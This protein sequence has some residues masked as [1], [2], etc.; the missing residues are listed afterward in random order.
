MLVRMQVSGHVTAVSTLLRTEGL[1]ES[2]PC[3][4]G[5]RLLIVD[6]VI[7]KVVTIKWF[8]V[9]VLFPIWVFFP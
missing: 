9:K 6:H 2:E 5:A 8:S 3:V 4:L 7:L 1:P